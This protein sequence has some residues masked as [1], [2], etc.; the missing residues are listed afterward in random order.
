MATL[1]RDIRD[2]ARALVETAQQENV[3]PQVLKDLRTVTDSFSIETHL[4]SS[5]AETTV[6]IETRRDAITKALNGNVHP[7]VVNALL[8]L[9]KRDLLH[10]IDAFLQSAL[11]VAQRT[12]GYV[13]A[14]ITSAIELTEAERKDITNN[15][16]KTFGGTLQIREQVDPAILG[17]LIADVGGKRI[18]NS[19]KGKIN[20]LKQVITT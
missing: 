8:A 4:I 1:P 15:L 7:Y 11:A 10:L 3:V 16:T 19:V 13:E 2:L 6:P 5:L 18:D 14:T 9:Q 12:S 17:G 20:R